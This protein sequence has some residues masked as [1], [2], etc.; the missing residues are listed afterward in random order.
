MAKLKNAARI[1]V[2]G[3]GVFTDKNLTDEIAKEIIKQ[4]P[5]M[6]AFI[7]LSEVKEVKEAKKK[8]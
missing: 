3:F 4:V 1:D 8:D 7:E 2:R 5:S 6:E